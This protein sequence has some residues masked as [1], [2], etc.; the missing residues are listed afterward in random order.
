[1]SL[2]KE[3]TDQIERVGNS[4]NSR[5]VFCWNTKV[6]LTDLVILIL[7]AAR[8]DTLRILNERQP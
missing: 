2:S 7:E 8:E 3:I 5:E 1:M 6:T 4:V